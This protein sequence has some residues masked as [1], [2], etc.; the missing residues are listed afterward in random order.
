VVVVG[1]VWHVGQVG[2]RAHQ[3]EGKA[4]LLGGYRNVWLWYGGMGVECGL[5][6]VR[7]GVVVNG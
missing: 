2:V 5:R 3:S 4:G 6:Q 7:W 1:G